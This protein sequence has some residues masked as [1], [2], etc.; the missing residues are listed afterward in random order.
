MASF[1]SGN[2]SDGEF[3]ATM[4]TEVR[5]IWRDIDLLWRHNSK[6]RSEIEAITARI[7]GAILWAAI[8]AGA[9]IFNLVRPRLGL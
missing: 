7:N 2:G 3:R 9:L 4:G 6:R 8:A 1:G 5:H